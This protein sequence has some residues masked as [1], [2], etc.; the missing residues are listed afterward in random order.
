MSSSNDCP[1]RDDENILYVGD[2]NS[3]V[4]HTDIYHEHPDELK[5][6]LRYIR[7]HISFQTICDGFNELAPIILDGQN[8]TDETEYEQ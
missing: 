8:Y 2:I 7:K 3:A 5:T 1:H 4:E 6:K